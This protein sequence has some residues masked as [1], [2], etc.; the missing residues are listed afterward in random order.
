MATHRL[1]LLLASAL[2]LGAAAAPAPAATP[3]AVEIVSPAAGATLAAGSRALVEWR[4]AP[5]ATPAFEEWEAFLSLDG[6]ASWPFRL[7]PHLDRARSRFE[8]E[9]PPVP[10]E[11]ALLLLRFGDEREEAELAAPVE[12]RL[13]PAR[14]ALAA[15]RPRLAAAPGESARPGGAGVV[16]WVDGPR[17]G[18]RTVRWEARAAG[19]GAAAA[20]VAGDLHGV[21]ACP[22]DPV[23]Q[24]ALAGDRAGARA[25]VESPAVR[26]ATPPRSPLGAT[27]RLALLSRRNE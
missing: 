4:P 24:L 20:V 26:S 16:G 23:P 18:R 2:A 11:R 27:A 12:L 15:S 13:L 1:P 21:C 9:L 6:G 25:A 10:A 7:T 19:L 8:V 5:G 17:D 22:D 14:G 3:A